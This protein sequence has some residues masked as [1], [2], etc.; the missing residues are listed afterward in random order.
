MVSSFRE[1]VIYWVSQTLVA[2]LYVGP[3]SRRAGAQ[4]TTVPD[5]VESIVRAHP[6]VAAVDSFRAMTVPYRDSRIFIGSGDFRVLLEHGHLLFKAPARALD[7]V[8][9][10]LGRD[11]VIASEAFALRY[12]VG[13]GDAVT[14]PTRQ[15]PHAFTIAAVHYD[16]SNDRGTVVMD[17]PVFARYF[18]Q[19][20]PTGLTVYLKPG[21]D[22]GAVRAAFVSQFGTRHRMS[23][24]T[25]RSLR[26]EVLRI[27]DATFAITWAL[28]LVAVVV[29]V[30]GV[31]ATLVTL[32][33][34]RKREL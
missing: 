7:A 10:T 18:D 13:V 27:F 29:A 15:G 16:Y 3:A 23:I 32:I 34:E 11:A 1:T 28:E 5:E 9:D 17:R 6:Q 14:L 30:M 26:N 31:V 20:R 21:A 33:V 4:E 12:K 24:Y 2:D 25:N 19:R 8:R 22:I